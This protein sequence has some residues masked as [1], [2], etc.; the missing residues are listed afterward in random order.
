VLDE[1]GEVGRSVT[2]ERHGSFPRLLHVM[3]RRR[4]TS[5]LALGLIAPARPA[6]AL[7]REEA[8]DRLYRMPGVQTVLV[9]HAGE[10]VA[11]RGNPERPHNIKSLSKSLLSA[12]AGIALADG[13]FDGLDQPVVELLPDAIDWNAA[14]AKRSIQ[15]R[16]LLTMTAGL[17]TTSQG[18]YGAWVAS[19]WVRAALERPLVSAPGEEFI[20]STGNSHLLSAAL[21]RAS[22]LSSRDF[23]DRHLLAPLGGEIVAWERSPEGVHFGGNNLSLRP[24]DLVAFG[25][26]YLHGGRAGDR[27][28]VPADWVAASTR[29]HSAGWPDRYGRYGYLW[30]IRPSGA[31]LAVGYG[32]QLL[33][34][35]RAR[36]AVI[37]V[38][39]SQAGK[40]ADWD[41]RLLGVIERG[42][43]PALQAAAATAPAVRGGQ[44]SGGATGSPDGW[45]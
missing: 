11:V 40:G 9:H 3:D 44:P 14:P 10:L 17:A 25:E 28:V 15:L 5:L 6:A 29:A 27:Q 45:R 23:L 12:A 21:A 43:L 13:T 35:D 36:D 24:I 42:L 22:G 8:V 39:S 20:Y 7:T 34:I 16:H 1:G 38:L 4:A 2:Q 19:N 33:Y 41:R 32:G 30:W 37:V 31:F 18:H 26:L